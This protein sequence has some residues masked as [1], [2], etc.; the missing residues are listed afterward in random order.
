MVSA[1]NMK[2]KVLANGKVEYQAQIWHEGR[3]YCSKTFDIEILPR[4]YKEKQLS[5]IV[6]GELKPAAERGAQRRAKASWR[7]DLA[8]QPARAVENHS[9]RERQAT[10]GR[11]LRRTRHAR[12]VRAQA[13]AGSRRATGPSTGG[14]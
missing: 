4:D 11:P 8:A 7:P 3:F 12:L 13:A 2:K 10:I 9:L 1:T 5:E 6:R 14:C